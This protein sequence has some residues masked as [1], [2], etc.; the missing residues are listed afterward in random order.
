MQKTTE[1]NLTALTFA[2]ELERFLSGES[3]GGPLFHALYG[4]IVDEPIPERLLAVVREACVDVTAPV[5]ARLL[6]SAAAAS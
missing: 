6:C 4:E 2:V 3:D 1:T 5:E